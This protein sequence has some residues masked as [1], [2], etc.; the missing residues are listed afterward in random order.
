MNTERYGESIRKVIAEVK[1]AIVGKDEVLMNMMYVILSDG[2]VLIEDNPGLAKTLMAKSFAA[3]LGLD[4]KRVQFTPDLLPADITGAYIYD[5]KTGEFRI[6]KGPVF[7]NILLADEINRA[8]PKTQS[9]LLESMQERQV[10][11]EGETYS[12]ERPFLVIATQNPIEQEGTYP[13]PEAQVDRFLAKISM[14]YPNREAEVEILRRRIQRKKDDVEIET[15]LSMEELVEIQ[16]ATEEVFVEDTLLH[17]I[18]D[19]T[20]ETR[21]H[22]QVEVGASPRGSIAILKLSRARALCHGRDYV[23]PEDIKAVTPM[24]L[25]HRIVMKPESWIRGV[26]SDDVIRDVLSKVPVPKV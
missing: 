3:A 8:P 23:T 2:H 12:I 9:A 6:M 18:T 21:R 25:R 14:G 17:Y 1:K 22:K 11:I 26:R 16:R 4:F 10:T 20:R 15:M 19:L 13:L 7:T 24:A 5:R